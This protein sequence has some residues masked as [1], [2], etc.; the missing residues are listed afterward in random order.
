MAAVAFAGIVAAAVVVVAAVVDC[1]DE[2]ELHYLSLLTKKTVVG[3]E[4]VA[5]HKAFVEAGFG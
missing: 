4:E 3:F 2:V 1:N 5:W